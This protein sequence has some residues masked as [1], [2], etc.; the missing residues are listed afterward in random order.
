M[1]KRKYD[2]H[3]KC[4]ECGSSEVHAKNLC[5]KCY[6]HKRYHDDHIQSKIHVISDK[7]YRHKC[8]EKEMCD[9]IKKHHEDMKDDPERLTTD[10]IQNFINVNCDNKE[11]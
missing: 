5:I 1:S 10:F 9:I 4:V 8:K 6:Y 7:V 11:K 2:E 3:S